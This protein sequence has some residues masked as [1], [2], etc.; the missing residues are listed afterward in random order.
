MAVED[1]IE[2]FNRI[3]GINVELSR[4]QQ[5]VDDSALLQSPGV[6]ASTSVV[7]GLARARIVR[8]RA[9]WAAATVG[10]RHDR[11]WRQVVDVA[12]RI[13]KS[14]VGFGGGVGGREEERT[15]ASCRVL[16]W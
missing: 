5:I 1:V 2:D 11:S 8:S 6:F 4:G 3:S 7:E 16:L 9:H 13:M 15:K 12:R 10:S 14:Q